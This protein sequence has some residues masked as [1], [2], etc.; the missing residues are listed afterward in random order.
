M[1]LIKMTRNGQ[2]T[3]PADVRKALQVQEGD[4]IAAEARDSG[5]F[6]KPISV[7]DREEADRKLE[8]IMSR[9]KY[10]GPEPMPTE[11]NLAAEIADIIHQSRQ[12]NAEGSAR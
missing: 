9:V 7:I 11:D 10:T 3:L 6:L 8:E 5:V 2:V 4:Y 1:S 12:D